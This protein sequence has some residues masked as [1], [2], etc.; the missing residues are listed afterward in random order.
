[1]RILPLLIV[2]FL[3]FALGADQPPP[4]APAPEGEPFFFTPPGSDREGKPLTAGGAGTGRLDISV[5]DAAGKPTFCRVAVVGPDGNFYQPKTNYLS[6]YALTGEWPKDGAWGNRRDKAPYR[7]LGRFFY[8]W[9]EAS[10]D[11]PAGQARVE[12]A[13]GMEHR[14]QVVTTHVPGGAVRRIDVTLTRAV[15]MAQFGYHNGDTH[16]HLPRA[17][18]RDEE[19]LLDL[20]AAEDIRYGAVLGFNEPAGPY[21]GFMEK[22]WAPQLR[23]L[24]TRSARSRDGYAVLSGQE[25]RS[26]VYGHLLLYLR[27]DIVFPG[28][29]FQSDTW[30]VHGEVGRETRERGGVAVHA[31]GGYAQEVYADAALGA[32]D[33]VELLQFGV[34]RGIGLTD[35]Y[36]ILNSGYR[37]PILGASDW[38]ACRFLGDCRTYVHH[39]KTP[40][41]PDWLRGAAEGHSFVTTGPLVLLEVDGRKPGARVDKKGNGP[42]VVTAKV[43]AVCEVTPLTHLDLIVNGE[44]VRRVTTRRTAGQWLEIEER[45]ELKESSWVAARAYSTTP[46]GRP[47]A[48]AHTNPVTVCLDGRA[49]YRQ[50]SLDVWLERID[51][52]IAVHRKR[53]FA[54][55]ARVLDYF[56]KARD[57]LL[58]IRQQGGLAADADPAKLAK[59]MDEDAGKTRLAADPSRPDATD[60]E[61]K[62]FLRPV[63]PKPPQEVLKTFEAVDGFQMQLVAAEP[64]IYDPVAAAFDEDGRLYVCEMR[65]Y[66]YRPAAGKPALGRIRLLEDTDGDGVFDKS[67][68]FADNLLWPAGVVPWKGGVFVAAPPDIWYLKDTKG[69]GKADVRR[70][71]FTGFGTENQQ[72][73]LNNLGLGLDHQ[74]YGATA[75]NG[76]TVRHA[77]RPSEPPV[78]VGGRDF[79]FD[80]VSERFETLTGTVQ[81]G[82]TFDDWGNRFVCSE[83]QP[84]LHVVLPQHYLARNPYLPVPSAIKNLAPGPV[85]V[86]RISPVERWRQIRSSR[87]I[88]NNERPADAAGASH[89][90]VDAAAGVTVYRGGAY[91][92]S[93]YGSVFTADGQNNLVHHRT[94]EPDGVSFRSRR[95]EEKTE[96]LRSSDLWFRP[97]NFVNA[98][99]GTLYCLDMSR[100]VLESIHIPLDVV[101]HLDLTNG[102]DNGRIYRMAPPGFRVPKPPRLSKATTAELVAALE[103]PHG[104]WRDTAH[105]L[106]YERQDRAAVPLLEKI[107]TTSPLPQA[108]LHALWSLHGMKALEDRVL[109]VGLNDAH[110]GV[111]ENAV[112]LAE[113]RLDRPALLT[114]VIALADDGDA[115]VRFQVAFTLGETR[116]AVAVEA[117]AKL[118]RAHA[119]D[120]WM[121]TAVLSSVNNLS[122]S[123][124]AFLLRD[125]EFAA[126]SGATIL[127]T[128]ATVVGASGRAGAAD[129]AL[130]GLKGAPALQR[131]LVIAMGT[132]MKQAGER[133]SPDSPL[134][135]P[136]F[137]E[138]RRTASD[139]RA[140]EAARLEAV[141]LLGC[142]PFEKARDTLTGLLDP[143]R[144]LSLQTAAVRAFADYREPEVAGLLLARWREYPP[145]VR[146]E[147]VHALLSREQWT[148]AYLRAAAKGDA[149]VAPVELTRRDLLVKHRDEAI[150][151]LASKLFAGSTASRGAVVADY[152]AALKLKP[153]AANGAR[154]FEKTCAACHQIGAQGHAVGP[155]LAS[156]SARD[157]E[158]LLTHIL[159]PNAYVPPN[160]VQYVV[161]DRK[162]RTF[163]GLIAAQTAT[164]ITLKRENDAADTILRGDIDELTSTGRSLMPEGLEKGV[165]KQEMA[166][167]IAFLMEAVVKPGAKAD[168][169][170]ERDFGT[171]P[172]P[173]EPGKKR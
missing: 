157:P 122:P 87:R 107:V 80:P 108:R 138:A 119:G 150:R 44:V 36:H 27:D 51:G 125:R 164:S 52:Q 143:R 70:K 59:L 170:R 136:L 13:K 84:L 142:G 168:P 16:L 114:K 69:D 116:E 73:M 109:L 104:W 139:E 15:P 151:S 22:M 113:S 46:G 40:T 127:E 162:G 63:P 86:F 121:R 165:S 21:V 10:V 137:D 3:P 58:R 6:P 28:R 105:R 173:V 147:V 120:V 102:R 53:A 141:R 135:G 163:T 64:L 37:F 131:R 23:G 42:H 115:R 98:P 140:G 166:D 75:G 19:T 20:L 146:A 60:A 35:W 148:L 47:D 38:P 110:S 79:R 54:E 99:D 31:H 39:P 50:A 34:Y 97:V 71:V 14:P 26:N 74:V 111:R 103:S 43:R 96:F 65:D 78:S 132:G 92:K 1:M 30:P 81:F 62:D 144:P 17:T 89:H 167:L 77:D 152:R 161:V 48:E 112:R 88:A 76:G 134:F 82:N 83:S 90:V 156:S 118:A 67:T 29:S 2:L 68:V 160:Y 100:E 72:A 169:T 25:Y 57:L 106:L 149:S 18:E 171:L 32:V 9:G 155:A 91:P 8:S 123:L 24:G 130:V 145:E 128:L 41:F 101:K 12:V 7:Y 49:P 117:L 11:V 45:L 66:P 172:G 153:D 4:R 159:D 154:V 33:G 133:L 55:K 95:F 93:Y 56:Q 129:D 126:G 94:L 124:F 85:P 61:L 158:A 5:R